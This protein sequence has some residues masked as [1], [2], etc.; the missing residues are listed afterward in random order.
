MVLAKSPLFLA[1][2]APFWAWNRHWSH[3]KDRKICN[4]A[5][6]I[7]QKSMS[8]RKI[9]TSKS[10]NLG[11]SFFEGRPQQNR[12]FCLPQKCQFGS[13]IGTGSTKN[14]KTMKFC[15]DHSWKIDFWTK[16]STS[17]YPHLVKSMLKEWSQRNSYFANPT[18]VTLVMK[19]ALDTADGTPTGESFARG[20][21]QK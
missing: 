17:K 2:G 16:K 11:K 8:W 19:S 3:K 13:E 9:S 18:G 4:F 10:P 1:Q 12:H 5:R 15:L 7:P 14:T 6:T 21:L 20:I